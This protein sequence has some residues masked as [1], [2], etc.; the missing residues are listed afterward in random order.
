MPLD[1]PPAFGAEMLELAEVV[2]AAGDDGAAEASKAAEGQDPAPTVEGAGEGP[3]L[4]NKFTLS[5]SWNKILISI[6]F[7]DMCNQ[8]IFLQCR[9]SQAKIKVIFQA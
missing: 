9:E 2:H 7:C 6:G 4:G 3:N 5:L 8:I 1:N